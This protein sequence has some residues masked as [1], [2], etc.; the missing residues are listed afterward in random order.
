MI[1]TLASATINTLGTFKQNDCVELLQVATWSNNSTITS[2]RFPN[3]SV[4]VSFVSMINTGAGEYSY[5]FCQTDTIGDDYIVNGYS[6]NGTH[7][8]DWAY[9]FNVNY[10]GDEVTE[11]QSTVYLILFLLIIFIF[12]ITILGIKQLPD[13][14]QKDEEGK[15]VSITWLKYLRP[16]GW[17]FLW[18]LFIAILFLSSNLAFAYL[19]EQLF[20]NVLFTLFRVCFALT[21]PIIVVWFIWIIRQM[22]H[23]KEMQ[24]LLN[25]GF[26]PEGK[27]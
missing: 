19:G 25:R 22:F 15:I 3:K 23:D 24:K 8:V 18:M 12:I 26:F 16:V 20:A 4:A 11:G 2:I 14:N 17:F 6:S 10:L 27:L 9:T 1:I 5:E 7:T 21:L 13:D